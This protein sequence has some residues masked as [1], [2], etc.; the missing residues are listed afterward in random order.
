MKGL[1]ITEEGTG[2]Q[3]EWVRHIGRD[4]NEARRV[5]DKACS[6]VRS[7]ECKWPESSKWV[8]RR[9]E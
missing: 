2:V 5:R 3:R 1:G 6:G 9:E 8:K 4:M 7:P